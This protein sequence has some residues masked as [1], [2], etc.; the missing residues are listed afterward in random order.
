M[1]LTTPEMF[2]AETGIVGTAMDTRI[3]ALIGQASARIETFCD[4]KF[5][6]ATLTETF[7]AVSVL[8]PRT[9]HLSRWPVIGEIT[10]TDDGAPV[11]ALDY[12]LDPSTGTIK[13]RAYGVG[14]GSPWGYSWGGT[15]TVSY[16]GGYLLPG[17]EGR[18][19]PEDIERICLDLAIR[20][21]HVAGRDP[22]LRSETVPGI[23]EQSWSAVDS[24]TTVGGLPLDLAQGLVRHM[25]VLP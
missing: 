1:A 13:R 22:A 5:A 21:Y 19:L 3:E 20:S 7:G 17:E 15:V 10:L 11:E 2:K 4:R 8:G 12:L 23:I 6:R 18:D 9:L 24:I 25:R 16:T 14:Y